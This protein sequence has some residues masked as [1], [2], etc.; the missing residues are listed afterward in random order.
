MP[1]TK[2]EP[3]CPLWTWALVV[4]QCRFIDCDMPLP[5]GD[6]DKGAAVP[7][8]WRGDVWKLSVCSTQFCEPKTAL[9]NSLLITLIKTK[10][11]A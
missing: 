6:G 5:G 10:T 1:S 9:K 4:R 8:G 7:S 2:S 11:R 3:Y